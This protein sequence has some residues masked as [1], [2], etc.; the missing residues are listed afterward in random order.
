VVMRVSIGMQWLFFL[1]LAWLVGP[2]LGNGLLAIWLAFI[3]Y[4]GLQTLA[5]VLLWRRRDWAHI[6]I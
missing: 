3:G 2:G 6:R 4:R 1:P 5:F